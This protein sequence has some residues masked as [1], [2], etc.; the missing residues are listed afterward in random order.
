MQRK[1]I[2]ILVSL[3]FGCITIFCQEVAFL[4]QKEIGQPYNSY[5]L[6]KGIRDCLGVNMF[7]QMAERYAQLG[8]PQYFMIR[9]NPNG[10]V[11]SIEVDPDDTIF[12]EPE[13]QQ[14]EH[15]MR[16]KPNIYHFYYVSLRWWFNP[17]IANYVHERIKKE[18]V[19]SIKVSLFESNEAA[20]YNN[21]LS[22]VYMYGKTIETYPF[23]EHMIWHGEATLELLSK[24][25]SD[26]P[27]EYL[28]IPE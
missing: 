27:Q 18:G 23:W 19:M 3:T 22:F 11:Q 20:D 13:L 12:T 21:Y 15:E 10:T 25:I 8:S 9:C 28:Y 14:L 24:D 26:N 2:V 1:L 5:M 16:A 6:L 17:Q 7:K 4:R